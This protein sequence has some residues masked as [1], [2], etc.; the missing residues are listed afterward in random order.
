[1][2]VARWKPPSSMPKMK[3]SEELR[4]IVDWRG[5]RRGQ[6]LGVEW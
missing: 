4:R 5:A 1:M 6:A 2:K 3:S